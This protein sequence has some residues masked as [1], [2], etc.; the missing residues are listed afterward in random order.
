MAEFSLFK[1]VPWCKEMTVFFDI[2]Y[3]HRIYVKYAMCKK[4]QEKKDEG[5]HQ[6]QMQ[7]VLFVI[8]LS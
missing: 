7:G 2:F 8:N 6:N 3:E 5:L 1:W 4:F